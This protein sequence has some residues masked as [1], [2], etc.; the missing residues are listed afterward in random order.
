M[1]LPILATKYG[2]CYIADSIAWFGDN[3]VQLLP[4]CELV[5][6]LLKEYF[7]IIYLVC[8]CVYVQLSSI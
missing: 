2:R 8:V 7:A 5:G 1:Y 4:V 3:T 6:R